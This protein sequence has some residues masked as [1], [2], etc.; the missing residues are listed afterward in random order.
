MQIFRRSQSRHAFLGDFECADA[1]SRRDTTVVDRTHVE[2]AVRTVVLGNHVDGPIEIIFASPE[3]IQPHRGI[4][5]NSDFLLDLCDRPV[6]VDL[7]ERPFRVALF[8]LEDEDRAVEVPAN[9]VID[10]TL[11]VDVD[12]LIAIGDQERSVP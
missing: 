8:V 12:Q 4:V 1:A 3:Q 7:G 9:A 11:Q 10:E 2:F 5:G 6:R